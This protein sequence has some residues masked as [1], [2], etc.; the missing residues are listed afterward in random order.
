MADRH[1]RA[2]LAERWRDTE[3]STSLGGTMWYM[4]VHSIDAVKETL[5]VRGRREVLYSKEVFTNE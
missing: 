5:F 3:C 1:G 4:N 2:G